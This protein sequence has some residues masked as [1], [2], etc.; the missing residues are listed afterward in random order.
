MALSG[1][2]REIQHDTEEESWNRKGE[3]FGE[4]PYH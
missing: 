2:V 3:G 1:K 4:Y